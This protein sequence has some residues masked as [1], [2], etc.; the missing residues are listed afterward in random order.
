MSVTTPAAP[1]AAEGKTGGGGDRS[2]HRRPR[3]GRIHS[4]LLSHGGWSLVVATTGVSGLNFLFHLLI[5]RLL[6][7][8]QYGAF[9]AVL[10]IISVLG[11]PLGAVQLTV[12][13]AV[14][15]V[16]AGERVSLRTL[17]V[18][19]ACWGVGAMAA[20]EALSPLTDS[21][22]SLR[23]PAANL[24]VGLWVPLAVVGAVLQGA[25]LGELG[26]VPVAIATFL[27]GGALRLVSGTL[28]VSAGYGVGGAVAATVIGQAFTTGLL[29]LVAR[30]EVFARGRN[31]VRISLRDTA[32]S[33]GALAGCATLGGIDVFLA[34][35]FLTHVAAGL[36]AAGA[37]AGHIAM[38]LPGA[39]VTV[40]FPRLV[41]AARTG[42]SVRKTLTETLGLVTALGLAAFA[43]LAAMPGV[44]VDVLFGRKYA[45]AAG[46]V[47]LIGLTSV[48]LGIISV[49]TYFHVARRSTAALFSW[50]GVGLVCVL[51]SVLHV[52]AETVAVCM[53]VASGSVLLIMCLPALAV[54]VRPAP[55]PAVPED[56]PTEFEP[57]QIDISLVIPF[58]NP[59]TQLASHVHDVIGVLRAEQA[60]FEVIAV[61][62]GSTDGSQSSIAGLDQ[63]RVI[64][65]AEN[66]GKGA[67]LRAGLA[68]GRGRYLGFIDADGDIP[69]RQL[70]RFL[71]AT[72]AG[73][74]DVVLGNKRHPDS[75]VVYPPL[76]RLYSVGYQ[77][78]NRVL[79]QLPVRDTQTG[80]KIIRREMLTAV[81][82]KM[83][84]KR[85]AFDLELLV[86][87]RR[88]GYTNFVE[89][90]VDIAERFTSSISPNSVWRTLLDTFGI[91]YRL[92]VR[93]FYG[94]RITRAA[95]PGHSRRL[96]SA[97][98]SRSPARPL[99][100][101]ALADCWPAGGQKRILAY[102]WRDLTHPRAGGAEVYLQSVAR[103]WVKNGHEVTLFCGS[104]AGQP[105][106]E[107]AD[108]VRVIR[109]GGRIGVY[110]EARRYWR[111][112]GAGQYDLVLDCVNT[113]P[114]LSPRFVRDVPVVALIHQVAREVWSYE[115][116]W[117]ISVL[118]RYLLEPAWLRTYRDVPVVTVSKSSCESLTEYGL[119]RITVVPEGWEPAEASPVEKESVPTVVFVGRLSANKR[120]EHAI[121]TFDLAR[122]EL[123]DAQLWVIGKGPEEARLRKMAGAGVTFFGHL[124]EAEKRDRVGR[125]HALVTTSVRE[126]WGL[127]VTEAA[128]T[129]TVA[130]GYDVAGLRDSIGASGGVLTPAHPAPL[131]KG[132]VQLV[133]SVADGNGPQASPAGV[134]PWAEV[135]ASILT[136]ARQSQSP[137]PQVLD[138]PGPPARGQPAGGG[139]GLPRLRAG[140]A[141]L[142][143]ALLLVSGARATA[144]SPVLVA[145]AFLAFFVATVAG[146]IEGWP[147]RGNCRGQRQAATRPGP[148]AADA[149][150]A[151]IGLTVVALAAVIAGQSWFQPGRLL[152]GGD[153]SPL[154]GTTWL[155]ELFVPWSW[156]GSN[157]GGP[158]ANETRLPLA[159]VYWL[160]N[161]L[162][163]S[164]ALAE[165]IWYV[166]LF[167]AAAAACYLLL[168]ALQLG[169]AGAAIGAL[170]YVLNAH[171][172]DIATNPVFLAAMVLLAGLPAVV[173]RAASGRRPLRWGVL[174]LAASA[175]LLGYV[176]Q[177]P[178]LVLAIIV[179]LALM[180]FL[181]GWLDGRAAAWRALRTLGFG[182]PLFALASAYWLV[183]TMLQLKLV[184]S[185]T[186]ADQSSWTWTEGRATLANGFWLNNDWGWKF[187]E[188]FPYAGA[189]GKLPLQVLIFLLPVAA[190]GFLALARFSG[191]GGTAARRARLGVAAAA[192]ALFLV[193]FSMGTR[194]PGSVVFD[195]LYHLP[196]GWLLREPGRFLMLGGLAYAVL[197]GLASAAFSEWLK[198]W[199]GTIRHWRSPKTAVA[200]RLATIGA[201]AAAVLAPG[202]PLMNG[203]VAPDQ[204]P[205]LPSV[206]VSVPTYWTEAASY[207]NGSAAP[208]N[209]LVLPEDDFYQMP[210]TWGYYGADG[211]ITDLVKRNVLDP[212][213]QGYTPASPELAGAVQLVQ[214]G[215]LAHDWVA[216][217]RTLEALGTSQLLV[218]GD[219]NADFPGRH[220]TPP[221]ELERALRE[222]KGMQ[223]VRRFGTLELFALRASASTTGST[224]RYVTV[225]S[226]TPDLRA[227][228]LFPSGT[229]LLTKPMQPGVPAV[230]ELPAVSQWQ[231]AGNRL[232]TSVTERSGWTY[233]DK[234]LT[235]TGALPRSATS[236]SRAQ[237]RPD[238]KISRRDGQVTEQLSYQLGGSVLNGGDMASGAWGQAFNCAAFPG[239]TATARVTGKVLPGQGPAG[240]SALSL[241]ASADSACATRPL[242]W[243]SGPLFISLWVRNVTGVA[244]RI[245]VY[246]EPAEQ[247]AALST[248][249]PNSGAPG[250]RRYQ[251]TVTPDPAT[252]R[253]SLWLYADVYTPG[254]VT[255]NE[256]ADVVVR[257]F[258]AAAQPVVVATPQRQEA[259][260][261][262]YTTEESFSSGWTVPSGA[263][264]LAVDG[265]RNGW[266]GANA[267]DDAPRFSSSSWYLLSRIASL[268]ALG[269]F[270]GLALSGST[271][272]QR[273]LVAV[274]RN[275]PKRTRT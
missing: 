1:P 215:L 186:L 212:V 205:V 133:S 256:Y 192:A 266:L 70:S 89:L 100:A 236:G 76:R 38:F 150:P 25:L 164:S 137:A 91:F 162:G 229:A 116:P 22:L 75:Q 81:L 50:A 63:V 30:K 214:Q 209:V 6:G 239:T 41:S 154:V 217:Q 61:S 17:T 73:G 264:R 44:V 102:N 173:L 185:A 53:L 8:A 224:T 207:L 131:A 165:E 144:L 172:V 204:R 15:S 170:A 253:L 125:A 178:P 169:P 110:R 251:A 92:R 104:V 12:T 138:R 218:R 155:R 243:R 273:R 123:P 199:L 183:P 87:A 136:V 117:P 103:E 149:W 263:A 245:C 272:G 270:L 265:L 193:L 139:G 153:M 189:Y 174:L 195:P 65:L 58:Y 234:L 5:S 259:V 148:L 119:R 71:A 79:F 67:A 60:S 181:A 135:A 45:D 57:A 96:A 32:L 10:N 231:E 64:E 182:A 106:E 69:A 4:A 80:I 130:I 77:L 86:V 98:R 93:H 97:A 219:V 90:P 21:F 43:V 156:S 190:F 66:Q 163:G 49:L 147:T 47:G 188:Y 2:R 232:E 36:Y 267:T 9:S 62:D 39:L 107:V 105:A 202:F 161:G 111:R 244:P 260:E 262:L 175:P 179:L 129:G 261:P 200:L 197:F 78:L 159:A 206:H 146:A 191:A 124:P 240:Q 208:G 99:D 27:G 3:S 166:G 198:P 95:A 88:M 33:I 246:E 35:H 7:P 274:V 213:S 194:F 171:V 210:Y 230:I 37:T 84:E 31:P 120:P 160:V 220:I 216:V 14:V 134:V 141:L 252:R 126:G 255:A 247:C 180:P 74:P 184:A 187:T 83:V 40:A 167:A 52:E 242:A 55:G 127:V 258:S 42:I 51:L 158:A 59:G 268:V 223:L 26:F 257:K 275:L 233:Q 145:A 176:S 34:R 235:A 271:R 140:L 24:A 28:L 269:L 228:S 115:T 20:A 222:D 19:A 237:A 201:L 142:G 128:A 227:L 157:L 168:R 16:P 143:A 108:G 54:A 109:R 72:R 225:D 68:Q 29:L 196:L 113:R 249:L 114:F 254:T 23:S 48:F 11:V 203:T 151:R 241:S 211:F 250:W 85:F 46:L 56:S 238:V 118:G 226:A 112:A 122:R 132:L 101:E 177:N 13:Q 152:A 121:R 94:P 82:P 18:K 248:P 221:A